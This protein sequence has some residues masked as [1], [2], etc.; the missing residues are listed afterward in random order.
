MFELFLKKLINIYK[1]LLKQYQDNNVDITNL[2]KKTFIIN[3]W[4]FNKKKFYILAHKPFEL[5]KDI[6]MSIV[7]DQSIFIISP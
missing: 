4:K 5:F 3:N 1:W 2:Q 6:K 7:F